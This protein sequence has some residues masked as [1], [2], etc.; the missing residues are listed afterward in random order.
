M[1]KNAEGYYTCAKM[2]AGAFLTGTTTS[3]L[4]LGNKTGLIKHPFFPYPN[5]KASSNWMGLPNK[6]HHY[7]ANVISTIE[8]IPY[9]PIGASI[10]ENPDTLDDVQRIDEIIEGILIYK[11]AGA[12]FIE[13]NFSCPN[14]KKENISNNG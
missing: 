14:I 2:G 5:S 1:F 10:A 13:I 6:G 8:K 7:V 4:R 9:C 12:D 3:R 11:K